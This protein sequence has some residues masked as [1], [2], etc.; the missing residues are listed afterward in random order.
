MNVIF[1]KSSTIISPLQGVLV[2][3]WLYHHIS[4]SKQPKW[5]I[6]WRR[7]FEYQTSD[8][9]IWVPQPLKHNMRRQTWRSILFCCRRRCRKIYS[10][11][12]QFLPPGSFLPPPLCVS[13]TGIYTRLKNCTTN[14]TPSLFGHFF[15]Q[16]MFFVFTNIYT[17]LRNCTKTVH[18]HFFAIFFCKTYSLFLQIFTLAWEIA[19][20]NVHLH[21]F[22]IFFAKHVLCFTKIYTRLKN[23]TINCTPSLVCR[24]VLLTKIYT[25]LAYL[26]VSVQFVILWFCLQKLD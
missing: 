26:Q 3:I 22:A 25:C 1:T 6:E 10:G 15:L 20:Q 23:C 12:I 21:L 24:F 5:G 18:L 13:D 4:I 9:F 7:F 16:N 2:N 11:T 8:P 14:C 17:C 19:P